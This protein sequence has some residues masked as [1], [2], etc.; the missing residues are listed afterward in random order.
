VL[1]SQVEAWLRTLRLPPDWRAD[2]EK[3]QRA[4]VT[5]HAAQPAADMVQTRGQLDR[6]RELYVMGDLSRE[7]YV[8]R[9]R[10]L[11]ASV[12]S[13]AAT[14]SY[15]EA[16]LVKAARLL[17]D[18]G[19]LWGGATAEER[20]EIAQT[21]F[22]EVRVRDGRIVGARLARDEYKL[23]VASATAS[24]RVGLAPPDGRAGALAKDPFD[25]YLGSA[26]AR[27]VG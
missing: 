1:E 26:T 8:R 9:R 27:A 13:G 4:A 16:V 20:T 21:L 2:V 3:M 23:L 14:P 22:A 10:E 6:L 19:D 11:E 18:L 24:D 7:E 25:W 12:A 15:T 5:R 17:S